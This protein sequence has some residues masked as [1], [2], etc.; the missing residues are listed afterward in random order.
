MASLWKLIVATPLWGKCEVAT[1]IPKNG[2]CEPSETPQNSEHNRRGQNTS[3]WDVLYTVG[4]VLKFRCPKWPRMSHLDISNISYG[5]KKGRE[6]NWQFD[7]RP[8]KVGNRL[9]PGVCRG[10][11]Q[12]VE[13]LSRRATSLLQ[14]LSQSE[15][16]ARSYE[17]PKSR[18]SKPGQFRDS[19]LG[20]PGQRAI[21]AW[22]RW[23]NVENTI[24]GKVVASLESG[25][26]WVKWVQ[27]RP[28]LVPTLK[29][30]RISSNQL[31]VGFGCRIEQISSVPLPSLIPELSACP[32]HPL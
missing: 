19:T 6:S 30:C 3:H 1:H 22:V 18:E 8:Q 24:W 4:K 32:F 16:R 20:V 7:S 5:R 26:W 13:K 10:V 12:T 28:W 23:S 31:V 27:G 29:G 11:R 17:H 21:R 25:P 15:V 9:A 14:T 2:T